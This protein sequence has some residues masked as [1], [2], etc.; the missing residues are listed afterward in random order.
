MLRMICKETWHALQYYDM[1]EY[2]NYYYFLFR[3]VYMHV[4]GGEKV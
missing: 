3:S 1:R 4:K 2:L